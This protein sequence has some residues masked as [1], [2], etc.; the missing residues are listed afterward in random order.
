MSGYVLVGFSYVNEV[1]ILGGLAN[2]L[3]NLE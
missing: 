3:L 1:S 2:K